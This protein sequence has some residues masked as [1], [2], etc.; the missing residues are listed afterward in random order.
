[1]NDLRETAVLKEELLKLVVLNYIKYHTKIKE[2]RCSSHANKEK[3]IN[4]CG[5]YD[6]RVAFTKTCLREVDLSLA[7]FVKGLK[8][9]LLKDLTKYTNNYNQTK[10]ISIMLLFRIFA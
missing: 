8:K 2:N 4:H 10:V 7:F 5:I 3:I 1:V 9:E 6:N